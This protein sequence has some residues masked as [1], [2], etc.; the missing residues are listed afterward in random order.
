M[1]QS[2]YGDLVSALIALRNTFMGGNASWRQQLTQSYGG[3]QA[4]AYDPFGGAQMPSFDL[5]PGGDFG[6]FNPP[7]A[8]PPPPRPVPTAPPGAVYPA[9]PVATP[10]TPPLPQRHGTGSVRFS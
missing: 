7:A 2:T 6:G 4:P 3:V 1:A 8:L 10:V 5:P 9:S